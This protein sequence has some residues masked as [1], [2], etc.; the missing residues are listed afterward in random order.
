M[1]WLVNATT[2]PLYPLERDT[3]SIVQEAGW[4]QGRYRRMRNICSPPPG[5]DPQTVQPVASRCTD[6]AI[7]AH[8]FWCDAG[9]R[10]FWNY[11]PFPES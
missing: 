9:I 1:G 2:R 10:T 4:A 6:Y 8:I 11:C 7:P 5:F 3:A